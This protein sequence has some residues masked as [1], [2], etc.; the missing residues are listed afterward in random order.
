MTDTARLA[1]CLSYDLAD[2]CLRFRRA[3]L[4]DAA[5]ACDW[6][7]VGSALASMPRCDVTI[8]EQRAAATAAILL[9]R[10]RVEAAARCMADL[11]DD[12]MTLD[13]YA[14]EVGAEMAVAAASGI[15]RTTGVSL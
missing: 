4:I 1:D 13:A 7:A 11:R 2:S 6:T 15:D 14:L 3:D 8:D 9:G 5:I 12:A 10:G